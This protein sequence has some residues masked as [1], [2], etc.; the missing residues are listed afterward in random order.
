[1]AG[2]ESFIGGIAA[3]ALLV[4]SY[5]PFLCVQD[6]RAGLPAVVGLTAWILVLI[7]IQVF[8]AEKNRLK[9]SPAMIVLAAVI[10]R[11]LWLFQEPAFSDDIYRYV[12]DGLQLLG[13]QSPYAAAPVTIASRD[14]AAAWFAARA[15]HPDMITIYPPAAQLVFAAGAGAGGLLGMKLCLTVLD[16]GVCLLLIRI[17]LYL[18]RPVSRAILYAWHP[19]PVIEIAGSGHIDAAAICFFMIA[20]F[21]IAQHITSGRPGEAA[22]LRRISLS[23]IGMALSVMT[24]WLPLML[25]P[26]LFLGLQQQRDRR[27]WILSTAVVGLLVVAPFLP[28]FINSLRTL[29]RYLG[30]WRFSGFLFQ[31]FQDAGFSGLFSRLLLLCG[32]AGCAMYI[33]ARQHRQR[34]SGKERL[35]AVAGAGSVTSRR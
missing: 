7:C 12:V 10:V 14:T 11:G 8:L 3:P 24:K 5:V 21:F 28:D 23:G 16:I 25:M 13:G 20:F 9:I 30:H 27:F 2:R 35:R 15:N 26:P 17:L 29:G 4:A 19:L 22:D 32:F 33:L 31:C 6:P 18:E 1:M 34:G